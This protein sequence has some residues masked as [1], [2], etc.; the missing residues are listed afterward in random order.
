MLLSGA[1]HGL[2]GSVSVL[3]TSHQCF[4]GFSGG[5]GWNGI[6]VAL[7]AR[8]NPVAVIPA[9]LFF[10]LYRGRC[11]VRNDKCRHNHRDRSDRSV[12][13]VFSD[14]SAGYSQFHQI[15]EGQGMNGGDFSIPLIHNSVS[16]MTPFLLAGIGGLMTELAG[17]LNIALEGLILIGG[18]FQRCLRGGEREP[19]NRG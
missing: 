5:M 18:V 2:A 16:I 1:L 10:S 6:A 14:N 3:G 19:S 9:A 17:M 13:R 11:E 15:R 7:I 8:N 4:K 12:R